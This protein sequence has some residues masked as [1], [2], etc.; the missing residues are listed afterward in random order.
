MAT[1]EMMLSTTFWAV[2]ALSRVEPVIT[3]GPL[4]SSIG[5]STTPLSSA[6]GLDEMPTVTAPTLAA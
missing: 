4:T 6:L 3:S 2:P 5:W 1:V